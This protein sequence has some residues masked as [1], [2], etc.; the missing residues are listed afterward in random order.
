MIRLP[1]PVAAAKRPQLGVKRLQRIKIW[2]RAHEESNALE[3]E[4]FDA[5]LTLWLIG[6]VGIVPCLIL[7]QWWLL[8][9]CWLALKTP[10]LYVNWRV[11]AHTKGTLRCGWI[12][13]VR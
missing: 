11:A 8:P 7:Q 5:V 6:W 13:A 4:A 1:H 9:L 10:A 3:Y 2:M 12:E